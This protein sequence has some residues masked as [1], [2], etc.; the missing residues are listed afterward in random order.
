MYHPHGSGLLTGG[1]PRRFK[2]RRNVL[3]GG[4]LR[5]F[6]DVHISDHSGIRQSVPD[7]DP[8]LEF[9]YS[10]RELLLLAEKI[11]LDD[12]K[13]SSE[14]PAWLSA[15]KMK[16]RLRH[17]IYCANGTPDPSISSGMY[18]RTHPEGRPWVPE[19]IRRAAGASFYGST[20]RDVL[21]VPPP[22]IKERSLCSFEDCGYPAGNKGLCYAH[23]GQAKLGMPLRPV[24]R[25]GGTSKLALRLGARPEA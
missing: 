25:H 2:L 21:P 10:K 9:E 13:P 3:R 6:P 23:Y 11:L 8:D 15:P 1:G 17:E 18:W 24:K 14:Y 19:N 7:F 5:H 22:A 12:K 4:S 16:D 20:P